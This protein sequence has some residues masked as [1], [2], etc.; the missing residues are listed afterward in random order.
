M[1]SVLGGYSASVPQLLVS[2]R[3]PFWVLLVQVQM[4]GSRNHCLVGDSVV[5]LEVALCP[6]CLDSPLSCFG[7]PC[8]VALFALRGRSK[9]PSA[10]TFHN[11]ISRRSLLFRDQVVSGVASTASNPVFAAVSFQSVSNPVSQRWD[12]FS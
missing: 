8:I 2:K 12:D 9:C 1:T 10:A 3:A 11:R 7:T 4:V 5:R 6:D